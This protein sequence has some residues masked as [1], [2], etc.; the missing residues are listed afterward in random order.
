MKFFRPW[1]DRNSVAKARE[2]I[3]KQRDSVKQNQPY[4]LPDIKNL[5]RSSRDSIPGVRISKSS[6]AY[7]ARYK[8][9]KKIY[10]RP[11]GQSKPEVGEFFIFGFKF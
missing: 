2:P 5:C 6:P 4:N 11:Y 9:I 10:Q 7:M 3:Q 1:E 8:M